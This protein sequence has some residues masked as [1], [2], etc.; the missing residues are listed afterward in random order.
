MPRSSVK[1]ETGMTDEIIIRPMQTSDVDNVCELMNRDPELAFCPW[2]NECLFHQELSDENG[3]LLVALTAEKIVG[4]LIGGVFAKR[5]MICHV[6]VDKEY[7]S[8]GIGR[9]LVDKSFDEFRHRGAEAVHLVVTAGNPRAEK[10]WRN[11]GFTVNQ[12]R[13]FMEY[14]IPEDFVSDALMTI[15]VTEVEQIMEHINSLP[16]NLLA[17]SEVVE[18]ICQQSHAVLIRTDTNENPAI[19]Y[20]GFFSFRAE[21]SE[22]RGSQEELVQLLAALCMHFSAKGVRRVHAHVPVG[23]ESTWAHLKEFGFEKVV[24]EKVFNNSLI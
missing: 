18:C 23:D 11:L 12:N 13:F 10:F 2:E 22:L 7:R 19:G 20:G 14:D 24:E 21:I 3:V 8:H 15:E 9:Q 1:D 6:V 17:N 4:A 5:A 16:P